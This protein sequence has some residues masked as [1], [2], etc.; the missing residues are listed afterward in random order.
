MYR[1][2]I[3]LIFYLINVILTAL[4][5]IFDDNKDALFV[6]LPSVAYC[7]ACMVYYR[8]QETKSVKK[9]NDK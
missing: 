3:F 1:S 2:K 8:I 4:F 7:F 6:A 5:F 9:H